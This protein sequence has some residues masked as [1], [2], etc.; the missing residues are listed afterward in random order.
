MISSDGAAN[1][2]ILLASISILASTWEAVAIGEYLGLPKELFQFSPLH[3]RQGELPQDSLRRCP[4]SILASA[5][6]AT[7]AFQP[8][9]FQFIPLHERQRGALRYKGYICTISIHASTWEAMKRLHGTL[10][11]RHFNSCLYTRGDDDEANATASH[12]YFN[13]RLYTRGDFLI[14]L[15]VRL[16]LYIFQ[17]TPLHERRHRFA[18]IAFST[19]Y[20][21][22]RLYTRGDIIWYNPPTYLW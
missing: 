5:W 3:E 15:I 4:I 11:H 22:S 14:K 1:Q 7:I 20:F 18:R 19:E 9:P 21:N 8:L 10:Q 6:E 17:F 2:W 12:H 16:F 13:S